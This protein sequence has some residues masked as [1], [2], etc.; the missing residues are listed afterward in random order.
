MTKEEL[1]ALDAIKLKELCIKNGIKFDDKDTEG[2]LR[3]L[4]TGF[5][6][7][8][9]AKDA[10]AIANAST[11]TAKVRKDKVLG[12]YKKCIIHLTQHAQ[13]N[14]S[15]FVSINLYTVEVNPDVEVE[16]PE[17]AI[18]FLKDAYVLEQYFDENA[19]SENGNKGVHKTRNAKKYIVE[20]L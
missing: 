3:F 12:E 7:A 16:L 8:Q 2:H 20:V 9:D 6:K 19:V 13:K 5:F 4:L 14:T 10:A 17:G 1:D 18:Q 11:T 15:V